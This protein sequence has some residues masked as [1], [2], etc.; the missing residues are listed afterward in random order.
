MNIIMLKYVSNHK[1]EG[2]K[3]KVIKLAVLA[4][5]CYFVTANLAIAQETK[6]KKPSGPVRT[7]PPAGQARRPAFGV[8]GGSIVNINMSDPSKPVL[9]IKSDT[10]G[11]SHLVEMTQFTSVTKVTDISELKAGESVRVMTKNVDGKETAINVMFGKI[12]ALPLRKPAGERKA[13][14]TA[15]IPAKQPKKAQT[16]QKK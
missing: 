16:P 12:R 1:K 10:D 8:I 13:G 2:A 15:P 9:E 7:M 5:F 4:I 6:D 3:M 14:Q 11:K